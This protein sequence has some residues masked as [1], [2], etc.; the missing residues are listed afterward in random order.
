MLKK[1]LLKKVT[2]LSKGESPKIKERICNTPISEADRNY[3]PLPR[4][5]DSNGLIVVKLKRLAK[6]YRHD[7]F[8]P[9]M[10]NVVDGF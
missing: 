2:I 3:M 8:E 6:Y 5:A 10:P 1:K 9:E 4:L 7:L